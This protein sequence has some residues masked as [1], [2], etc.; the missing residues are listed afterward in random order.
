VAGRLT[1]WS[2]SK[3]KKYAQSCGKF[4]SALGGMLGGLAIPL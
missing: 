4:G 3:S 2:K 1:S